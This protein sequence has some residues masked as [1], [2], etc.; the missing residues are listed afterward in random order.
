MAQGNGGSVQMRTDTHG[1]CRHH[2]QVTNHLMMHFAHPVS[3][4]RGTFLARAPQSSAA[5]T[6]APADEISAWEDEGGA[7]CG[8]K[9]RANPKT[10]AMDSARPSGPSRVARSDRRRP[11]RIARAF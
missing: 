5:N 7:A 10:S 9:S 3:E 11:S 4:L 1:G 2:G 6:P 8:E